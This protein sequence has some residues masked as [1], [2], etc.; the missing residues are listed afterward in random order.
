MCRYAAA[1]IAKVFAGT[2]PAKFLSS[3]AA[4]C[5]KAAKGI[6]VK[7]PTSL[8]ARA[9]VV[10]QWSGLVGRVLGRHRGKLKSFVLL[11]EA[12]ACDNSALS[13]S[14]L[15]RDTGPS[16]NIGLPYAARRRKE[17]DQQ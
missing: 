16:L 2:P 13:R 17:Y 12:C 4:V 6:G 1:A 7:L 9:P 3:D 11:G 8:L 14:G 10:T 5:L 15:L